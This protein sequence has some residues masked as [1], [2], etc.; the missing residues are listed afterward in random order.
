M[1][2]QDLV[3]QPVDNGYRKLTI[4]GHEA[5]H[6]AGI[7][8]LTG[9]DPAHDLVSMAQL[10]PGDEV[11]NLPP[12]TD[13]LTA[14]TVEQLRAAGMTWPSRSQGAQRLPRRRRR[15]PE[16]APL[17][18]PDPPYEE[19]RVW[20]RQA[21]SRLVEQLA[22]AMNVPPNYSNVQWILPITPF[23]FQ[24]R[25]ANGRT[26]R[27]THN[28]GFVERLSRY[29]RENGTPVENF[30]INDILDEGDRVFNTRGIILNMR[31]DLQ[32]LLAELEQLGPRA[33]LRLI[34]IRRPSAGDRQPLSFVRPR[35]LN[36]QLPDAIAPPEARD[37]TPARGDI[38]AVVP[39]PR[40][41]P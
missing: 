8:A 32:L 34:R 2:F 1:A 12:G 4:P 24:T 17:E 33:D 29:H 37:Y 3:W 36:I 41:G 23:G 35:I 19:M 6:E 39:V 22:D 5:I 31:T 20:H 26:Q 14:D 7:R 16:V 11:Y 13:C 15:E 30:D 38:N 10:Q 40:P 25:D 9:C 21:P 27:T 18:Q 28:A